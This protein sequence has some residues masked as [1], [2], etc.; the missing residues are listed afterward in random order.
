M[1]KKL[2]MQAGEIAQQSRALMAL[3]EVLSSIRSNHMVAYNHL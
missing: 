2:I 1:C 3:S